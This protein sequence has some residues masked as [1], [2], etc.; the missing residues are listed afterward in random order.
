MPYYRLMNRISQS[1]HLLK[2]YPESQRSD[3]WYHLGLVLLRQGNEDEGR[4]AMERFREAQARE[5]EEL[6]RQ[7]RGDSPRR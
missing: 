7:S 3:A 1:M 4:A 2:L 5:D 6:R